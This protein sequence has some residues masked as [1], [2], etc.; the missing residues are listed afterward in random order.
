MSTFQADATGLPESQGDCASGLQEGQ[1]DAEDKI[2]GPAEAPP[3]KSLLARL[4]SM[5]PSKSKEEA[6]LS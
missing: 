6:A 4:A 2:H 3:R 5:V 1:G